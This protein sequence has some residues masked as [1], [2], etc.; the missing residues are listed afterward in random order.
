MS[1]SD[2]RV[3]HPSAPS[4]LQAHQG[5]LKGSISK[6][7]QLNSQPDWPCREQPPLPLLCRCCLPTFRPQFTTEVGFAVIV[8][9]N[10][11]KADD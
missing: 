2:G 1:I 4:P 7:A 6:L 8:N 9:E 11:L 3:V 10:E 5:D